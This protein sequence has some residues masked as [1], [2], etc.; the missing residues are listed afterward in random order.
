MEELRTQLRRE[1]DLGRAQ[2]KSDE[3][4]LNEI[5][6]PLMR[7]EEEDKQSGRSPPAGLPRAGELDWGKWRMADDAI[8][9]DLFVAPDARA[10]DVVCEVSDSVLDVRVASQ[11]V[12]SGRLAHR[13]LSEDLVWY[14]DDDAGDDGGSARTLCIVIPKQETLRTGGDEEALFIDLR[15]GAEED[16]IGA[17]GLVAGFGGLA[18]GDAVSASGVAS[19]EAALRAATAAATPG[20]GDGDTPSLGDAIPDELWDAITKGSKST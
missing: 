20:G 14:F 7:K 17:A 16:P 8:S 15:V 10:K 4:I 12:L 9:L 13:V 2:G 11:P 5:V 6:E 3:E 1:L 18:E 19:E